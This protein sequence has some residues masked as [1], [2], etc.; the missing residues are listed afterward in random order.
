MD[1]GEVLR[2]KPGSKFEFNYDA[3]TFSG[4]LYVDRLSYEQLDRITVDRIVKEI[5]FNN[6]GHVRE[7]MR[8]I[9]KLGPEFKI[10]GHHAIESIPAE[11][12]GATENGI[13]APAS[14]I[15]NLEN[16]EAQ[17]EQTELKKDPIK[18]NPTQEKQTI[19]TESSK[20]TPKEEPKSQKGE[21]TKKVTD[22]KDLPNA[23]REKK[24]E[25]KK[26][27]TQPQKPINQ[28]IPEPPKSDSGLWP[29]TIKVGTISYFGAGYCLAHV[30]K[31]KDGEQEAVIYCSP[32]GFNQIEALPLIF[33][34]EGQVKYFLEAVSKHP[35]FSLSVQSFNYYRLK[36]FDTKSVEINAYLVRD[37]K[38]YVNAVASAVQGS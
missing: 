30:Y 4:Y 22:L 10:T 32:K 27:E 21:F 36:D 13:V 15:K 8:E 29:G 17:K 20:A 25:D 33:A 38:T 2:C 3:H 14:A 11:A 7:V 1:R 37:P 18:M 12:F 19:P 9:S 5:D 34:K 31:N 35:S 24:S 6:V 23:M 16:K 26:T 28:S